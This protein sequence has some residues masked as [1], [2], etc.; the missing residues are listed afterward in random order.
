MASQKFCVPAVCILFSSTAARLWITVS[1]LLFCLHIVRIMMFRH[2]L[3]VFFFFFLAHLWIIGGCVRI[4]M[5]CSD[6]LN[7]LSIQQ[8]LIACYQ[9]RGRATFL[10]TYRTTIIFTL[11]RSHHI[12]ELD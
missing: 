12:H 10:C 6:F 1:L 7:R 4:Q 9:Y 5:I 11:L 8:K 3:L 2:F